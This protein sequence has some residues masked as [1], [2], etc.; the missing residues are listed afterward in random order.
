MLSHFFLM[1]IYACQISLFFTVLWRRHRRD[2][3]KLFLQLWLGLMGGGLLIG[4]LMYPFP[5][6]PP[7]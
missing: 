3:V 6:S 7:G 4:W 2:Q 5:L 1:L